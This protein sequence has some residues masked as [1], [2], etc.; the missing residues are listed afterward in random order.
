M[1]EVH[2]SRLAWMHRF[3][4]RSFLRSSAL[5]AAGLALLG[6]ESDGGAI[7]LPHPL[8]VGSGFGGSVTALRLAEAGI[9]ATVLE[10]GRRWEIGGGDT[11]CS[12]RDPDARAAWMS[13][14]THIGLSVPV[15]R[16]A[17]LVE[18][19]MGDAI[20]AIVPA[21][22]G[23]GSL[24]YAGMMVQP[25]RDLF[26]SV[27][28]SEV[29][30]DAMLETW[31]PRVASILEPSRVPDD[32][33]GSANYLAT[34]IFLDHA[35]NAGFTPELNLSA[36]D[37]D[38][39]R[40][41][42]RGELPPEATVGDYIYGLNSGAKRTLDRTYLASAEATGLVDVRPLHVV[43]AVASHPS[44]GYR[45]TCERIDESGAVLEEVVYRA[46][47]LFLAAG[48]I[49][50]TR[51]LVEARARGDLPLLSSD[52]GEGWGHNGQH[53]FMRSGLSEAV[54]AYQGG[55]PT[56]VIRDFDN[57]FAPVTVEHGA[58][59]FGYDCGCMIAPSSS[60][61]DGFGRLR[62]DAT[63]ARTLLEWDAANGATGVSAG[64]D[65]G[66]RLNAANGGEIAPLPGRSRRSTF[67]P[68]GGVVMG[69]AADTFG[70]VDGY[71]GLYAVDGSIVPG[72]T[73]TANPCWTIAALAERAIAEIITR[74]LA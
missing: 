45:V 10:R 2:M 34:R 33:L 50:T 26:A 29:D 66:R 17:G 65:V 42:L 20:D 68:L 11:F 52:V 37:W 58:A 35:E 32:I 31:Y 55:P 16:Y 39:V 46:P 28:P 7:A 30:Y 69:R 57:P 27:F 47:A 23:G 53:I 40:A 67:H 22:V 59:A 25:P 74:D 56:A 73:P 61:P 19:Y 8:I 6:C 49:H 70:R 18:R 38:L 13:D 71:S 3:G 21:A 1:P 48:S 12:M 62:Y 36:I 72:S 4:R 43:T 5:G 63:E 24:V 14:E 54:G 60:L 64:E 9:G 41:E 44:G 51:L 15:P